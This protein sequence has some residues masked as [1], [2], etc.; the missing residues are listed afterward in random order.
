MRL[1]RRLRRFNVISLF[2]VLRRQKTT[3][4][5]QIVIFKL[6]IV[7][8]CETNLVFSFSLYKCQVIARVRG[9]PLSIY[10]ER[11]LPFFRSINRNST[12]ICTYIIYSRRRRHERLDANSR[13]KSVERSINFLCQ[14]T[15]SL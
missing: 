7:Y 6:I 9:S 13:H 3:S 5:T 12:Y 11:I 10:C 4:M 15:R 2:L 8:V 1:Q 14:P